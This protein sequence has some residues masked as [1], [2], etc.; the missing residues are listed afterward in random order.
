MAKRPSKPAAERPNASHNDIAACFADYSELSG[1]MGRIKQSI[2]TMF[3]RFEKMGVDT[4][5]VKFAY[6]Q[7]QK[8]DA[9]EAHRKRTQYLA[10]LGVIDTDA[11]GQTSFLNAVAPA[12]LNPATDARL[13]AARAHGDGYN[14][15]RHGGKIDACRFDAGTEEFVKWRE[16]FADGHADRIAKDPEADRVTEATPRRR[17]R[18]AGVRV[19]H[20]GIGEAAGHA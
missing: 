11:D 8:A 17:G 19:A 10:I 5:S 14:T 12:E 6:S 4:K 15:G 2:A 16:G 1:T 18:P 9:T 13:K 7:A 20:D 3:G